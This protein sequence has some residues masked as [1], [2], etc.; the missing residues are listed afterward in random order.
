MSLSRWL[1]LEPTFPRPRKLANRLYWSELEV[2]Q[3][4]A[5]MARTRSQPKMTAP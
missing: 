5:E 4:I 3:W 2:R 1:K